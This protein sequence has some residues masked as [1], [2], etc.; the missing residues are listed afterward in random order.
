MRAR[1]RH[2][3]VVDDA[4]ADLAGH[5]LLDQDQARVDPLARDVVETHVIARQ[6]ATCAMPDPI[7]PAPMTPTVLI[8]LIKAKPSLD[9]AADLRAR[10]WICRLF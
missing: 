10:A 4:A 9:F 1:A 2:G 3:G 5:V 8:S 6:R 7:W